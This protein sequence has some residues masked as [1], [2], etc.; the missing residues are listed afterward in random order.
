MLDIGE[1]DHHRACELA[2]RVAE[3]KSSRSGLNQCGS[4]PPQA[5]V[6]KNTTTFRQSKARKSHG[7]INFLLTML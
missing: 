2:L 4:P 1:A 7:M 6:Y 3:L 5:S